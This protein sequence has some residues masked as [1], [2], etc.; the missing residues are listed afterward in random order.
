MDL[1]ISKVTKAEFYWQMGLMPYTTYHSYLTE[2]SNATN[3]DEDT[4][5]RGG[6][7]FVPPRCIDIWS[8]VDENTAYLDRFSLLAPPCPDID[9]S[10]I[11][12]PYSFSVGRRHLPPPALSSSPTR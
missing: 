12:G 6:G 8:P 10:K 9:S 2:C 4:H 11:E 3:F 1:T 7:N 5:V